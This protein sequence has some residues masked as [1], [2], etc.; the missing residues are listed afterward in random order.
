[1]TSPA[2]YGSIQYQSPTDKALSSITQNSYAY[3]GEGE[4]LAKLTSDVS[5]MAEN[6]RKMQKGID[7]ANENVVQQIQGLVNDVVALFGG[8][9]PDEVVDL[10]D[11]RYIF[12]GLGALFG[13]GDGAGGVQMPFN[14]FN[15]ASHFMSQFFFPAMDWQYGFDTGIDN[16]ISIMLNVIDGLHVPFI[17]QAAQDF[18]V[19]LSGWRDNIDKALQWI[20]DLFN[21]SWKLIQAVWDWI[22]GGSLYSGTA[23]VAF[24][25]EAGVNVG[26]AWNTLIQLI[27]PGAVTPTTSKVSL[28]NSAFNGLFSGFD[29]SLEVGNLED[30]L[31]N[32]WDSSRRAINS[33]VQ[34][35]GVGY[36]DAN[37]LWKFG[38]PT[39]AD[40]FTASSS[41]SG[42]AGSIN[43]PKPGGG[44][45]THLNPSIPAAPSYISLTWQSTWPSGHYPSGDV[46][47][48]VTS[49]K[50]STEGPPSD[51]VKL[52]VAGLGESQIQ[53]TASWPPV[54]GVDGYNL[55]RR[56]VSLF[57]NVEYRRLN[58]SLL[59]TT[60][61][62]DTT[63]KTDGIV[64]APPTKDELDA[65]VIG[66]KVGD[67]Q[68]AASIADGKAVAA[69]TAAGIADGKAVAAQGA[70]STADGKAVA[71]QGAAAT[72]DSKAVAAQAKANA[73]LP[74]T[75]WTIAQS[76]GTN[77][78]FSPDFEDSTIVR[79]LI[80]SIGG[81]STEQKHGGLQSYKLVTSTTPGQYSG[82]QLLPTNTLTLLKV[83]PG[84]WFYGE[85][86]VYGASTNSAGEGISFRVQ[87]YDSTGV[88]PLT[89]VNFQ[90]SNNGATIGA[91]V[92]LSGL[93]QV[94]A[95]YDTAMPIIYINSTVASQAFYLDDVRV[96]EQTA[97]Q[98]A[99]AAAAADATTKANS[100]QTAAAADAQAKANAAQSAAIASA[101]ADAQAK[102]N[103][104]QSAA[105]AAAATTAQ[106][107]ADAA[108]A[109]AIAD[110]AVDAQAKADAALVAAKADA[111]T[112]ADAAEDAATTA[113]ALDAQSKAN[114]AE[115]AAIAAAAV[116]AQA[117]ANAAKAD[118]VADAAVDAQ[119]K[120]DAALVAAK[121]DATTK[122]DAVQANHQ[123]LMD[124]VTG[125]ATGI[126]ITNSS[127]P[128]ASSAVS[129]LRNSIAELRGVVDALQGSADSPPG[130]VSFVGSNNGWQAGGGLNWTITG[131][132]T[133]YL[134][135]YG[136]WMTKSGAGK[137]VYGIYK[138]PLSAHL[139]S[140]SIA[141]SI[142]PDYP[143]GFNAKT[144]GGSNF[145]ILR[146]TVN[147]SRFV[148]CQIW[149]DQAQFGY[150]DG[151]IHLVGSA[152]S[153]PI[154]AT[155]GAT[156]RFPNE[157]QPYYCELLVGGLVR[158]SYTF[159]SAQAPYGASY[160]Y[161]GQGMKSG[162]GIAGDEFSPGQIQS[163]SAKDAGVSAGLINGGVGIIMR[164]TLETNYLIGTG[165][166]ITLSTGFFDSLEAISPG[167]TQLTADGNPSSESGGHSG[168]D[169]VM[170]EKKGLYIATSQFYIPTA[171]YYGA[172]FFAG[173]PG[174]TVLH[175]ENQ[176]FTPMPRGTAILNL[177]DGDYIH[178][179][180]ENG[181]GAN[182]NIKG[183]ANGLLSYFAA[184]K[185]E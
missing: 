92:K 18:A 101:A 125:G 34:G 46:Y 69:Q 147:A 68:A 54:T 81:Y 99:Q 124:A 21:D 155:A 49:V 87:F 20:E 177:K 160:L 112:K 83:Q 151:S 166:I 32:L 38:T 184:V 39:A 62:V 105:V 154:G 183:K 163:F 165:A 12:Q 97:A 31:D 100:A 52:W 109:D 55:Y 58:S 111:Q 71:A 108:K 57:G 91:W 6:Q 70:A 116:T 110:A 181:S 128:D 96:V 17:T 74:Q 106:A 167:M 132:G 134:Q 162:T 122:A 19:M 152:F 10:G 98:L 50:G 170:V 79:P 157:S 75:L 25:E 180:F 115:A 2:Q 178:P 28:G 133:P 146:S 140:A 82:I 131:T 60:S 72:A 172:T 120:A 174:S 88:N 77:L 159:S 37:W 104:A 51:E 56:I 136:Y 138:T 63:I 150:Y 114:D 26:A 40:L 158:G 45:S 142:P 78:I 161:T 141:F 137:Y 102:A 30:N 129:D 182:V 89:A 36:F 121:A 47:F 73:A 103:A 95:G 119:S 84:Q 33:A 15:A 3:K 61:F 41:S 148:F 169:G 86:W 8:G 156:A 65:L 53:V 9:S 27:F 16:F 11:F 67:A 179:A 42:S 168:G 66:N 113:A 5:F 59:T 4:V 175:S 107:K 35:F 7:Q 145:I 44:S 127:P 117:K 94:P 144:Y 171:Q 64:D 93:I 13:L 135:N 118:A 22:F 24:S 14:L 173:T 185:V 123:Q 48:C 80:G 149:R 23:V 164:R 1:M 139:Q 29:F 176:Y 43:A 153:V 76:G 126:D 130:G 90:N 85:I 143:S